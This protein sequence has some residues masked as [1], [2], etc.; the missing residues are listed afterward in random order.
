[1]HELPIGD[2]PDLGGSLF[3]AEHEVVAPARQWSMQPKRNAEFRPTLDDPVTV[4]VFE[5]REGTGI[6]IEG[7]EQSG[8]LKDHLISASGFSARD[9]AEP[10]Q[11]TDGGH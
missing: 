6:A 3:L 4:P 7:D 5:A 2:L 1:Q 8:I 11:R 9:G 10:R